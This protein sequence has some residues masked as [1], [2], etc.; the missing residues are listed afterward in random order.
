MKVRAVKRYSDIVRK[1]IVE[2]GDEFDVPEGRAK[3]LAS[4]GMVE[5]VKDGKKDT[6]K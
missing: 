3:Y 4:Q 2:K 6:A 5:L 1:K